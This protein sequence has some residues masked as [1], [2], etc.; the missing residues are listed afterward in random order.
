METTTLIQ[1]IKELGIPTA[2]LLWVLIVSNRTQRELIH[3]LHNIQTSLN[4]LTLTVRESMI[5]LKTKAGDK[6]GY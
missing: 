3:Q 5:Y 4:Q 1:T 2:I 6:I